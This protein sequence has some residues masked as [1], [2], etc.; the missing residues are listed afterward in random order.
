MVSGRTIVRTLLARA[1]GYAVRSSA[2]IHGGAMSTHYSATDIICT[3]S[4]RPECQ[5][6]EGS[7]R[8]PRS[9]YAAPIFFQL[10]AVS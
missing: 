6:P 8:N 10:E 1:Y 2:H 5:Q 3:W 7:Q 9:W 4:D